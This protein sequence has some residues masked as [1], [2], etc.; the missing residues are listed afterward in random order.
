MPSAPTSRT[1]DI[2]C[3]VIDNF[4][5]IGV[6]WR[7]AT[8]LAA[9]G[10]RVRL[11]VD[12]P[13]ALT[14]MAPMGAAGVEVLPWTGHPPPA[15]PADVL[16]E[17]F[18]CELPPALLQQ[19]AQARSAP[20]PVWI[21]LE[22]LS[23]EAYVE[24][25]HRLPSPVLSGPAS[26]LTRHFFYPGFTGQTGGLLR[27]DDLAERQQR[28]DRPA[29]LA[30][31]LPDWQGERLNSLFCYEPAALAG[32]LEQL[33]QASEPTR[34]LVTSGRASAAVRALSEFGQARHGAL[35]IS[36][37]DALPQTGYDELL[38][39]CDLNFV[40]GEDSLVRAI[41]AGQPWVWQIYPQDDGAHYAKLLALLER[42]DL[43]LSLQAMHRTWNG[44]D[45]LPPPEPDWP[46]WRQAATR[47]RAQLWQA[48]G[49]CQQL[50]AFSEQVRSL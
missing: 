9:C 3:Q 7:L 24:R 19:L 42:L 34:L 31:H 21:N 11:W 40:R 44:L 29:W 8:Q 28:F 12:D 10:Q 45:A 13:S 14:W 27:E 4:G 23:A 46:V 33:S 30:R 38:W 26:G 43:P 22:Y 15:P 25:C 17:A 18:G 5:D 2:A 50:M 1:W 36:H 6:C 37:L 41:W 39:A 48:E 20:A 32:L 35:R 16:I 47:I 49:L